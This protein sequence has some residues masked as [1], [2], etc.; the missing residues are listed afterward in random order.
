M[1]RRY[2]VRHSI[3]ESP[4][5]PNSNDPNTPFIPDIF[6]ASR[7]GS[8]SQVKEFIDANPASVRSIDRYGKNPM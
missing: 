1:M 2:E 4:D 3:L 7:T 5:D 6:Y 8:L